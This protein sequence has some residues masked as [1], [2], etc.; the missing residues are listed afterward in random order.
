MEQNNKSILEAGKFIE[1]YSSH[2]MGC[3]VHTSRVIRSSKRI[4]EALGYN[5]RI[6]VFQ[7]SIILALHDKESGE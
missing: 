3:G 5:V 6:S 7:K 2:M 1:E 4:G